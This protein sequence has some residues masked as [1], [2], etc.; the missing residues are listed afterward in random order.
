[1]SDHPAGSKRR[2]GAR[3]R[4]QQ[5]AIASPQ[6][7][8]GVRRQIP[9]Y[10][11]LSEEGLDVIERNTDQILKEVG[12]EFRGDVEALE[13]WRKAGADVKGE[14]VR[15]DPGFLKAIIAKSSPRSFTQ[16]ARNPE[17]SVLMFLIPVMTGNRI[18]MRQ[19]SHPL[20]TV[21]VIHREPGRFFDCKSGVHPSQS[22]PDGDV[23]GQQTGA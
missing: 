12:I 2:S 8:A 4:K 21:Q 6:V 20:Q 18:G 3:T 5:R 14:R 17:R 22:L 9:T 11:L 16:H 15:F 13:L 23:N 19:R 1:M 7:F 10:Q